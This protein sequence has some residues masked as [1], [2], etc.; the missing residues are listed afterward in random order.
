MSVLERNLGHPPRSYVTDRTAMCALIGWKRLHA[1]EFD[2]IVVVVFFVCLSSIILVIILGLFLFLLLF[3]FLVF[4]DSCRKQK[5]IILRIYN[6][7]CTRSRK[8][9]TTKPKGNLRL[10]Y[11][12]SFQTK[13]FCACS[14][15]NYTAKKGEELVTVG[16]LCTSI[17]AATS[18]KN[19][20]RHYIYMYIVL[21]SLLSWFY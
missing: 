1:H 16:D 10:K 2:D 9:H 15:S 7:T 5:H 18:I 21:S 8:C 3:T 13:L 11:H 20:Y 12:Y 4:C 19:I 17:A 14:Q 6:K